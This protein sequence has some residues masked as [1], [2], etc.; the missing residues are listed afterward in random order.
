MTQC[1]VVFQHTQI[2]DGRFCCITQ[3]LDTPTY[4]LVGQ[5]HF[6]TNE[7]GAMVTKARYQKEC[8]K[9]NRYNFDNLYS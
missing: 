8:D 7:A 5:A 6:D 1:Y 4:D 2:L 3:L 9:T